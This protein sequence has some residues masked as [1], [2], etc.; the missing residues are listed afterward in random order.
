MRQTTQVT[1]EKE[2]DEYNCEDRDPW[3]RS[4]PYEKGERE[5]SGDISLIEQRT[6]TL[7]TPESTKS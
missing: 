7:V 6:L 2:K 4:R 5:A 3:R 1:Q